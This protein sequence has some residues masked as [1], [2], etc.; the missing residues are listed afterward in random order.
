MDGNANQFDLELGKCVRNCPLDD[1]ISPPVAAP[2][3]TPPTG[4]P[5]TE[6][7]SLKHQGKCYQ[8]CLN[9]SAKGYMSSE[10]FNGCVYGCRSIR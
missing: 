4:T 2:T 8:S 3:E 7:D 5:P 9:A 10:H 6:P 1:S